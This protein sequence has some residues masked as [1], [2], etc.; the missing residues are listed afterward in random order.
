MSGQA[1]YLP[2]H[3]RNKNSLPSLEMIK[4]YDMF[5][6][7]IPGFQPLDQEAVALLMPKSVNFG[8]ILFSM[9]N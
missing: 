4:V 1:K 6:K 7:N 9:I 8:F 2:E 3:L 5:A